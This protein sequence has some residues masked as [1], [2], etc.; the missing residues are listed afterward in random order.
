MAKTIKEIKNE[1]TKEFLSNQHIRNIYQLDE[2]ATFEVSFSAVSLESI[3]FGIF[4]TCAWVLESL[5]AKHKV[6]VEQMTSRAIV[7]SVEWYHQQALKFQRGDRLVFNPETMGYGYASDEP[8]KQIVKYAAVRDVG[9][10]VHVLVS[11]DKDQRP[12]KL[13]SDD[14]KLFENY[15]NRIKI[16]G[17]VLSIR[18]LDADIVRIMAQC[19]IDPL[20]ISR[21][22][23]RIDDGSYPV[24]EAI[25]AYLRGIVYG[26][27]LNKTKLVDAIQAVPG[28]NDVVLERVECSSEGKDFVQVVGNNYTAYSGC[29]VAENLKNS[30]SYVV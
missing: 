21:N 14:L 18:S 15:M 7:A 5:M 12:V 20:V 17:V 22:G 23:Q 10:S 13:S 16:A 11:G 19:T 8:S 25:D 4:A 3:L 30:L 2:D 1:M 28:V 9:N 26:G 6:E 24:V 27:T 29:F